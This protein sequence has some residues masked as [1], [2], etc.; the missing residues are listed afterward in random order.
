MSTAYRIAEEIVASNYGDPFAPIH[1]NALRVITAGRYERAGANGALFGFSH[2]WMVKVGDLRYLTND[3]RH[4]L[5]LSV[6][7]PSH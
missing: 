4:R 3:G 2:P 5:G 1:R 6:R 7:R